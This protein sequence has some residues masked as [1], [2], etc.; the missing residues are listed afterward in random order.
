MATVE[1]TGAPASLRASIKDGVGAGGIAADGADTALV[2]V[3]VQYSTT[4]G[5]VR[6]QGWARGP[7]HA[8][9]GELVHKYGS[10]R[11]CP[12]RL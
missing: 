5:S 10:L 1:T 3:Q 4:E 7:G 2:M 12:T 6:V 9:D 8:S 11:L